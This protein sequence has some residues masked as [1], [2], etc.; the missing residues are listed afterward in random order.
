MEHIIFNIVK[1]EPIELDFN[2]NELRKFPTH[3]NFFIEVN[4]L[5][6][7]NKFNPD[8]TLN[9]EDYIQYITKKLKRKYKAYSVEVGTLQQ[10]ITSVK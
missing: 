7:I 6:V 4:Q 10:Q 2:L 1:Q 3:S 9:R 5:M 8:K